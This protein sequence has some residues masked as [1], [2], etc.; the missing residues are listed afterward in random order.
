MDVKQIGLKCN[1]RIDLSGKWIKLRF[2][3]PEAFEPQLELL[4][5]VE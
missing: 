3:N 2:R 5:I 4:H 1:F